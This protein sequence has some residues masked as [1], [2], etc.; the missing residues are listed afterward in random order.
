MRCVSRLPKRGTVERTADAQCLA[1]LLQELKQRSGLSYQELSRR[2]FSTSST[3][4]RYCTGVVVP[5]DYSIVAVIAKECGATP[6]E[7]NA[8]LRYWTA[9]EGGD[10][11]T[12]EST[13]DETPS[14]D[15]GKE[16][17]GS[18]WHGTASH[19]RLA[20][21]VLM[22][23]GVYAVLG[24]GDRDDR[25]RNTATGPLATSV[26]TTGPG[27]RWTVAPW[28]VDPALF[29]VTINSD[30][31]T[32][33]SFRIGSVRLWDSFTR[34]AD[35]ETKRG[36][37]EWSFL[38]RM[39]EGA[40]R[41]G[42]PVLFTV[43]GTPEWAAPNGKKSLYDDDSRTAPPDRLSDW[44]TFIR[45]LVHRYRGRI[46]VY[47]L[48][49]TVNDSHFY[50]GSIETL[51]RMVRQASQIVKREDPNATVVCPS[52]GHL[53]ES[54]GLNFVKRFAQHGGFEPCDVAGLKMRQRPAQEP[55]EI[56]AA[57]LATVERTMHASGVGIPFWDTGPD[58]DVREQPA[59]NGE[60]ARD[61]AARFFLMGLYGRDLRLQ[62]TYFYNW[63]GE[64]IPIVLQVEGEAP[65][66]AAQAID[67]LQQW[68][69]K[70]RIRGCG[71]GPAA[72][73]PGNVWQCRFLRGEHDLT[74]IWAAAGTAT[75]PAGRHADTAYRLDGT[76]ARVRHGGPIRITGAPVLLTGP[77]G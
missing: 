29:G 37:F 46:E 20:L 45:A 6:A 61:Y 64:R 16:V 27:E 41:S 57:E 8:L 55:P 38:D 3:L 23:V 15:A 77:T 25:V 67:R 1:D 24:V 26:A 13:H 9:A 48:W 10:A 5:S 43:G 75:V 35:L 73:L 60:Q 59:V 65:T 22:A 70:A 68:L 4:H 34:W 19:P 42:E 39:V 56:M 32:M 50:S 71:H 28:P 62:R 21:F 76:T 18:R 17:P 40:R 53:R 31:G 47:E 11:H 58:Y 52:M 74:I 2:T 36:R 54:A 14:A 7:L 63:G 30:T 69:D 51:V 44:D 33:P 49:D 12:G 72:G 66:P